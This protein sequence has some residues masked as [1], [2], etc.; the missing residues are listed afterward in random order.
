MGYLLEIR[1]IGRGAFIG[2]GELIPFL[3]D[4]IETTIA[5]P[6]SSYA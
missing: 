6:P 1:A 5:C 2:P 3:Q 4:V